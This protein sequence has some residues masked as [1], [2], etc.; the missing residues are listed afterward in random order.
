MLSTFNASGIPVKLKEK[1]QRVKTLTE[2][3]EFNKHL[4]M[5]LNL[6][7]SNLYW[8]TSSTFQMT[9]LVHIT[10]AG[11]IGGLGFHFKHWHHGKRLA[12]H[13]PCTHTH[14]HTE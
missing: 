1:Q 7:K 4:V 11:L 10:H 13:A 9:V 3:E 12:A 2:K 14:T 5:F 8:T 6:H